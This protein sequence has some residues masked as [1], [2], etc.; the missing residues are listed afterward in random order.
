[1]NP[2]TDQQMDVVIAQEIAALK[3]K[4]PTDDFREF[5]RDALSQQLSNKID[6][7]DPKVLDMLQAVKKGY[8][9]SKG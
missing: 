1:M 7:A 3:A 5:V 4:T 8:W 9:A 2:L 6:P